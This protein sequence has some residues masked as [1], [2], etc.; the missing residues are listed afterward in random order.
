MNCFPFV[1]LAKASYFSETSAPSALSGQSSFG[2]CPLSCSCL[3]VPT[4]SSGAGFTCA[5]FLL[6]LLKNTCIQSMRYLIF[7]FWQKTSMHCGHQSCP[8]LL[9]LR[10]TIITRKPELPSRSSSSLYSLVFTL[11]S[12][13]KDDPTH[14]ILAQPLS[15]S[16]LPVLTVQTYCS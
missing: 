9:A 4:S 3:W 2:S 1:C 15:W 11:I 10:G 14:L 12:H 7:P 13:P 6:Y 5:P 16:L 8:S